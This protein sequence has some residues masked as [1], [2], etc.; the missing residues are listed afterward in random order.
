MPTV[1]TTLGEIF[2]EDQGDSGEPAA[3]LWP[4][5]LPIT[6]CGVT[7]FPSCGRPDGVRLRSIRLVREEA[8]GS[9]ELTR[10]TSV[11]TLQLRCWTGSMFA[12]QY[13]CWARRGAE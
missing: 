7:R 12:H 11:P 8:R 6:G 4:S 3:L 9:I 1:P 5:L 2:V 13:L 10:W